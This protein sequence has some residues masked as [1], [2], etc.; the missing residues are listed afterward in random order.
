MRR[1]APSALQDTLR[2]RLELGALLRLAYRLEET[3]PL[4]RR[5]LDLLTQ[6]SDALALHP[7]SGMHWDFSTRSA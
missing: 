3:L 7:V 4:P 2:R 6:L 5:F 1:S